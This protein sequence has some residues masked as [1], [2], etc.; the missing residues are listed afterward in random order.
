MNKD[1]TTWI[2]MVNNVAMCLI[3]NFLAA[4]GKREIYM[5]IYVILISHKVIHS[6]SSRKE[7]VSWHTVLIFSYR[8]SAGEHRGIL[9]HS[10]LLRPLQ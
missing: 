8:T 7:S 6:S 3:L 5:T 1:S 4:K 10:K 9:W 2:Y